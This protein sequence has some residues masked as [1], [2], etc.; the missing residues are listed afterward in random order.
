MGAA[1]EPTDSGNDARKFA[2]QHFEFHAKQRM[3]VFKAYLT[4]VTIIF[5]GYGISLQTR[6]LVV[7]L[8]LALFSLIVAVI[9]YLL[10]VRT[11]Q[12]IKIA[13]RV[14]LKEERKIAHALQ[15]PDVALFRKSDLICRFSKICSVRLSYSHLFWAF[16]A[17][18]ALISLIMFFVFVFYAVR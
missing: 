7:G 5:A 2:W 9:F 15:D 13:E 8:L 1:G 11:V 17:F 14:L 3:D 16:C 12:L 18:S 4:L 6:A 10:D